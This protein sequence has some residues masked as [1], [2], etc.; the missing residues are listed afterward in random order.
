M[1]EFPEES[2]KILAMI[3]PEQG[4][5][6]ALFNKEAGEEGEGD[7]E[8]IEEGEEII[9]LDEDKPKIKKSKKEIVLEEGSSS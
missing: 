7:E 8:V 9:D 3:M 6:A 2:M 5:I 1:E 4:L